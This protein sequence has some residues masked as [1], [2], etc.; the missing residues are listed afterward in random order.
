MSKLPWRLIDRTTWIVGIGT[1]LAL[2]T[3]SAAPWIVGGL[4]DT[5]GL[6]IAEAT[7]VVTIEQLAMGLVMIAIAPVLTRLP[8][9][10]ATSAAL[11]VVFAAQLLSAMV[12]G[13]VPI[14]ATRA[15]SGIALG[16]VY[17]AVSAVG[18]TSAAPERTY[19]A[20]GSISL[21]FGVLLNPALGFG[22]EAGGYGGMFLALAAFCLIL[23]VPLLVLPFPALG[24]DAADVIPAPIRKHAALGVLLAMAL[25][26]IATNGVFVFVERIATGVGLSGIV[27]G[28]GLSVTS[29]LGALGGVIAN[30]MGTRFGTVC[31]LVGALC[32]MGAASWAMMV[33]P[34]AAAFW[35]VLSLWLAIY[36]IV[37]AYLFGLAVAIDVTGRLA[38]ATGST[39]VLSGAAGSL[40]AGQVAAR[41]SARDYGPM[42]LALCV[43]AAATGGGTAHHFGRRAKVP[44][45]WAAL[46]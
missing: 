4:V 41:L 37:Y 27:L 30:R 6:T 29:L 9:R 10:N 40:F 38:A 31:P 46:P 11:I 18:A 3:A 26:A 23:V 39:L 28:T 7:S 44:I 32:A 22:T 25:F 19:A 34:S 43:A 5:G 16:V 15:L 35:I 36:W 17:S 33:V 45:R 24:S 2:G 8:L 13:L 42:A 12:S 14:A 1:T 20:A 21:V